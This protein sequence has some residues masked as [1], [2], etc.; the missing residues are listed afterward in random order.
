MT[1]QEASKGDSRTAV[2]TIEQTRRTL[3]DLDESFQQQAHHV[4]E[5]VLDRGYHSNATITFL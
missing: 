3:D 5:M 2:R 1:V 4:R